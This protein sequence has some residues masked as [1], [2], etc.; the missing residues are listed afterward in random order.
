MA[1]TALIDRWGYSMLLTGRIPKA[2]DGSEFARFVVCEREFLRFV[3]A[4]GNAPN[5]PDPPFLI[6]LLDTLS[7]QSGNAIPAGMLYATLLAPSQIS[8]LHGIDLT[9]ARI[10]PDRVGWL[11]DFQHRYSISA[12]EAESLLVAKQTDVPLLWCTRGLHPWSRKAIDRIDCKVMELDH[13]CPDV[14]VPETWL[15]HD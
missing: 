5:D 1:D 9:V 3:R 4:V 8:Y 13:V 7:K 6:R 11:P 12:A 10:D 14:V 15:R 2:T